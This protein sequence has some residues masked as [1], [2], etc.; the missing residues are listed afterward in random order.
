MNLS[1]D[2]LAFRDEVRAFLA[3]ELTDEI[4]L[5]GHR[6]SGIFADYE[7]GIPWQRILAKRGWAAPHWP[8]EWGGC[9]WTPRQHDI[10]ASE[11]AAAD[12]PKVSPLG[13][14]MAAPVLVAFGTQAQKERWLPDLRNGVSYWCQ[15]YS[16]PGSGSDLA[17]LQCRA[18]R[19]GNEW[20]IN[21][22]KIWTTHAHRATHMFCL[23]RTDNSGKPQQGIS[24][25]MFELNNPGIQIRPIIS[26]SGDHE[27]NQVFFDE[28]RVPADALI[29]EENQGWTI[30]KFLLEHER[31]GSSAPFLRGRLAR[32]KESLNEAFASSGPSDPEHEDIALTL[33]NAQC[34]IDALHAWEQQVLTAR[35]G[36]GT[37]PCWMPAAP[38]MGK[39][40][41]TELKQHLTELGL[42]IAGPYGASSLTIEE[43]T[44]HA[45][46][47]PEESVFATRAYLND[48]AASIY[49]GTNE[50]QRN[51]IARHILG[52]DVVESVL[53]LDETQAMLVASLQ[54]WLQDKL[55]FDKRAQMI[56]TPEAIGPLW[57]GLAHELGLLGAAL[58]EHLGG[59]GGGLPE[60]LLICQALGGALVGEPYSSSAVLGANLL[61]ALADPAADALLQG[62][63]EGQVRLA[64]AALEPAGR[65]DLSQ[66][67]TRLHTSNGQWRITGRKALVRGAPGATH[68]LVSTKDEAGQL[69]ICLIDPAASGVQR[70]EIRLIDGAWA[71]ELAFD[72]TPV[73]ALIGQGD[74]LAAL[75]QA[76][77][78]ATLAAGAEAVGVMQAL[79]RDTLNYTSQRKQF[80]QP[81]A[82]FQALQHRMA[83]MYMA[84][85]Q[86]AAAVGACADVLG[87]SPE[88]RAERVS[89]AHVTVLHAA[90]LV[91]QGAVQLHGGMGMTD[92]LAVGHGFKRLTVIEQQF[93]GGA[94]HLRRVA[95][96]SRD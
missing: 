33:A 79:M 31:G 96:L 71:A 78:T 53:P 55:P 8:V 51:L 4:R 41:A 58:P 94:L 88:R 14:V 66:V 87:D 36:G 30:A 29:G 27:F 83:D 64:V 89:S 47:V 50:V 59:M 34:R 70:R 37:Q 61:Q 39:V 11:M 22:S 80:G 73:Q 42:S 67:Q 40:L 32:L 60:Q 86:A 44:A 46:P 17:S 72:Q 95:G 38:S 62:L 24:F 49:G 35:I 6:T 19:E 54:G 20:V 81:L 74:A 52:A 2:E 13:L 21:G 5:G 25:L 15:G 12:A 16:E 84:L 75:S 76:W 93:G 18:R 85:V 57:Q 56:A 90:R 68:W 9:G 3:A 48:R 1:K 91:G 7:V 77:D 82:A 23:V 26:I 65:T 69:R 28:A 43:A 92:E 45:L 10:F 63:A